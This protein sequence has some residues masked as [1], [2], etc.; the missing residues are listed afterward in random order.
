MSIEALRAEKAALRSTKLAL[1]HVTAAITNDS[2]ASLLTF[3]PDGGLTPPPESAVAAY[4]DGG[5]VA[6]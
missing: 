1:W 3:R 2:L 4:L 5:D 6:R